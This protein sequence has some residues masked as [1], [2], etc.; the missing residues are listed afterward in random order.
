MA[1]HTFVHYEGDEAALLARLA[2]IQYDLR[3]AIMLCEY[4][5]DECKRSPDSYPGSEIIDAFSTAILVRYS[6]AFVTGVRQGL[7]AD[8]LA[9]LNDD[10]RES[11]ERIRAFRDKHIAHSVNSFEETKIQARYCEERVRKEGITG[12][13]L[14]HYRVIGLS[15]DDVEAIVDVSKTLLA[16]VDAQIKQE[17]QKVLSV[18]RALPLDQVLAFPTRAARPPSHSEICKRRAKP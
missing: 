6:R 14:E 13:S 8:A 11:H 15:L 16:Y 10:Q 9:H 3:S 2:S 12:I 18:V 1:I 5:Q 17:Q 7:G 4:L